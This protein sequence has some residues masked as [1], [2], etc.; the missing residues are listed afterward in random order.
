MNNRSHPNFVVFF[1]PLQPFFA[2][3]P[4][5]VQPFFPSFPQVCPWSSLGVSVIFH[6]FS[7]G[8]PWFSTHF[9]LPTPLRKQLRRAG[10]KAMPA[11]KLATSSA[12]TLAKAWQLWGVRASIFLVILMM[13]MSDKYRLVIYQLLIWNQEISIILVHCRFCLIDFS[14]FIDRQWLMVCRCISTTR[15]GGVPSK[16]GV[17]F[18]K[19]DL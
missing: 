16:T 19:K 10:A 2:A 15:M 1:Q 5:S 12:V 14:W 8:F 6:G 9:P 3:F 18:Q 13:K 17:T 7:L 4:I 11:A